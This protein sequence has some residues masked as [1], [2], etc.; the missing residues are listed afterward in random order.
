MEPPSF[1][2]GKK[3]FET[4]KKDLLRWTSLTTLEKKKQAIMVVHFLD[5]D[6]SGIKEKIDTQLEDKD[7]ACDDGIT[8]LLTFLATIYEADKMGDSFDKYMD[9]EKK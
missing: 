6:T 3:S 2:S 9:F 4:Y 5:D 7:L 8:N 1:I